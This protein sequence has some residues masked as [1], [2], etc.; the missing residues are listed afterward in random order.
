MVG[1]LRRFAFRVSIIL[2][3]G[4]ATPLLA[5]SVP[6]P[7][8][9]KN[10][11]P[12]GVDLTDGTFSL[13][14][15]SGSIGDG[16][17]QIALVN[18]FGRLKGDNL[19]AYLK[20]TVSSGPSPQVTITIIFGSR[21]ETFTAPLNSMSFTSNQGSGATLT[22]ISTKLYQYS[23]PG[24]SATQFGW[25]QGVTL[26]PNSSATL[27]NT[28][29]QSTCELVGLSTTVPSGNQT[30]YEWDAV[31][32]CVGLACSQYFRPKAVSNGYGYRVALGYQSSVYSGSGAPAADWRQRVSA[33]FTNQEVTHTPLT[34]GYA[35]P[36]P[37]VTDVTDVAGRTTRVTVN[38][39]GLITGVKRPGAAADS[40][41]LSYSGSTVSSVTRNGVT[42]NYS[43]TVSGLT[44]TM[45]VT[46]A[47]SAQATVVSDMMKYRPISTTDQLGRT[48]TTQFDS[49]S[50]L[51]EASFPEGNKVQYVYD[52]RGNVTTVSRIAKSGSG[53]AN[54]VTT[55]GFDATCSNS[56]TCDKPNW[57]RDAKGNQTDFSYDPSIGVLLSV[58]APPAPNGIRPQVRFQ[59]GRR[60]GILVPIWIDQCQTQTACQGLADGTLTVFNYSGGTNRRAT[61]I[62][63]QSGDNLLSATS[64]LGYDAVGNLVTIDGPLPGTADTTRIRYDAARQV[65][66]AVGPD[67]DGAG[68]RVPVAQRNTYNLDGQVTQTEIGTVTDQSDSAWAAFSSQQQA[69]TTYDGNARP[70]KQALAAG[71]TTYAVAQANYDAV[72]RIDCSVQRMDPA[73][74]ATQT[75]ACTPQ[76]TSANGPDRVTKAL[77]DAADQV[78]Q[79]QTAVGTA[80][81]ANE[82]STTYNLNG[83]PATVTDGENNR[84]SY[85]YDGH[86]RLSQTRYPVAGAAGAL[87]SSTTD[88]GLTY[89]ANSN[90]TQRRLRDAKL[91][92]LSYDNLNRV[93]LKDLPLA[94]VDV[95]Y[96]YDLLNRATAINGT[97]GHF[98]N[99]SYDALGWTLSENS[100][101]GT[102][103][104]QYDAAGRQTRLTY[105][106]GFFVNYDY[107]VTGNVTAIRENGAT[108]GIG[109]LGTYAYDDLGRRTS[110]TR[111]NG[112]VTNYAFDP[113]SRL[114]S[115]TQNPAGTAQDLTLG[116]SYN[117]ASQIA[118]LTRSTDAYAWGG[119]Y[120]VNRAYGTNGLNQLT[121]AGATALS[122]DGRGNLTQ[123][124]AQYYTYTS[125][126]QL[127][128]AS[129]AVGSGS[130]AALIYDPVGRLQIT[131]NYNNGAQTRFDY[132]GSTLLS[133]LDTSNVIVR[134]YVHGPDS[135]EPL[136]WY[137]GAG[138]SDRRFPLADERGSII[139][140][141]NASGSV[142]NINAYDEYGIPAST[143]VG[144]FGYTGQTWLPEVGM[145]YYKARIYSPQLGR[146]M[147]SDPI[148]Y[149]DGV[150]FY[151]YAG[152]D[153]VNSVDP[154]GLAIGDD[155]DT[156]TVTTGG[157]GSG[158]VHSFGGFGGG[159]GRSG[160]EPLRGLE[161][162]D[163]DAEIVVTAAKPTTPTCGRLCAPTP[164]PPCNVSVPYR[165]GPPPTPR[166]SC[167]GP[168]QCPFPKAPPPP[169]KKNTL[170]RVDNAVGRCAQILEG[171]YRRGN[172]GGDL[173]R[174][175]AR[176]SGGMGRDT[177]IG[178]FPSGRFT[179]QATASLSLY[180]FGYDV[181]FFC[182]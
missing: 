149:G 57:T 131:H 152:S 166:P 120:N 58:T 4:C 39:S 180:N 81:Q 135:D 101:F 10:T 119:H 86:D 80:A 178:G 67:P 66:G 108:T 30:L 173:R 134:R 7:S 103:A 74:W 84:T 140:I 6:T 123:S 138:I 158:F 2:A 87:A 100:Y 155:G 16:E 50:R 75:A 117:P 139:A 37:M 104:M 19:Q 137:E 85:I 164:P 144:R 143:N 46:N 64:S 112:A 153:P 9:F 111:G 13:E 163:G 174:D 110:L 72:G 115:F 171:E 44:A 95:S 113:V 118:S 42:T 40:L 168:L 151:N 172:G 24:K 181:G 59:Y 94:E 107:D 52:A 77:Y 116:F 71:G 83:T 157:G 35:N 99:L 127:V 82:V 142:T 96:T 93:T 179:M 132:V 12:N 8:P 47:L 176:V 162:V 122:Y 20:R 167:L 124:G 18:Y 54:I 169:K 91:I 11:D 159:G 55:A 34:A 106:D 148:G 125:E 41:A 156:I 105:P 145:N 1:I 22:K 51:T 126:N 61:S 3:T 53:L 45:V 90:I 48:T 5:Q 165:C 65:A 21:S 38:A 160:R 102:K 68:P 79:V 31:Q 60:N 133:E 97:N 33:T 29:T 98:V 114:S 109:V 121:S 63:R 49:N 23:Q 76:T 92:N 150:N 36:S 182:F 89:D 129:Q 62:V 43:H 26:P 130:N 136:V 147:Q 25:P 177:T 170:E 14:V 69:V 15:P 17:G 78:T 154:S 32:S 28:E 161:P 70:I 175:A 146:F 141:T 88:E 73:Q 128:T 56:L 27:C